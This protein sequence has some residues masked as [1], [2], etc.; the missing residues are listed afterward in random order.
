MSNLLLLPVIGRIILLFVFTQQIFHD[1][2]TVTTEAA[3]FDFQQ[4]HIIP[5]CKDQGIMAGRT[6]DI[7]C[8]EYCYPNSTET[9]DYSDIE[10]DPDYVVRNTICRCFSE[11]EPPSEK[12]QTFECTSQAEVWD[13]RTPLMKCAESFDIT[14]LTTCQKFCKSI[15]PTAYM[16]EGFSGSSKCSCGDVKVCDDNSASSSTTSFYTTMNMLLTIVIT[17]VIWLST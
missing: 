17:C 3:Y 6:L 10:E 8:T 1:T 7:D 9:F 15:D 16:Y 13:K 2:Q 4:E 5:S 14:S 11:A 12:R